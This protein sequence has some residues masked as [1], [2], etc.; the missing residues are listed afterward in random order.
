MG[1][2]RWVTCLTLTELE[3]GTASGLFSAVTQAHSTKGLVPQKTAVAGEL[4]RSHRCPSRMWSVHTASVTLS[5]LEQPTA[6]D[7]TFHP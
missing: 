5:R 4:Q 6:G 7:V 1:R 3:L 2:L